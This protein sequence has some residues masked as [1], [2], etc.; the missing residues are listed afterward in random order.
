M[1]FRQ[2]CERLYAQTGFSRHIFP[3]R[4]DSVSGMLSGSARMCKRLL[5][6]LRVDG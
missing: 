4:Y 6:A 5:S 2:V 3:D 1:R